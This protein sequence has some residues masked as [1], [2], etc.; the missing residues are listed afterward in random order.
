MTW[1]DW[2][3]GR[4]AGL[5]STRQP[6]RT[7][8][9]TWRG[10]HHQMGK[11]GQLEPDSAGRVPYIPCCHVMGPSKRPD[12]RIQPGPVQLQNRTFLLERGLTL[13]LG[14]P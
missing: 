14:T 13:R 3:P 2:R 1:L 5:G 9:S 8:R 7:A 11:M 4:C 6:G 12:A 10:A